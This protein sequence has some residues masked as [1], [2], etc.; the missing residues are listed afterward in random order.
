[1]C[2]ILKRP[3]SDDDS[4]SRFTP[5]LAPTGDSEDPTVVGIEAGD[6]KKVY[7]KSG[8]LEHVVHANDALDAVCKALERRIDGCTL[9]PD[10]FFVDERGFRTQDA[11]WKVPISDGLAA[12]GMEFE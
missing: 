2:V 12:A 10:F 7:V 8:D 6:R 4:G 3:R 5:C 11:T 1:M 9:D